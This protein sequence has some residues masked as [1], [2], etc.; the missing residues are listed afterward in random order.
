MYLPFATTFAIFAGGIIRWI[1]DSLA[2]RRG[3]NEAQRA[4]VENAGVLVSSGLIAG[5][6]LCGLITAYF[7][8]QEI[9]TWEF[10]TEP[11]YVTGLAVLVL[12]GV[13]L[14]RIPL[15]AAGRPDEPAPPAAMM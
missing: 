5:E 11:S 2:A 3:L 6:A 15:G 14:V 9:K 7:A 4:R 10:F 12:L 8:W 13:L 1:S